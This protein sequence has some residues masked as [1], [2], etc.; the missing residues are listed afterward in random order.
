MALP[1]LPLD[2]LCGSQGPACSHRV[3]G[4]KKGVPWLRGGPGTACPPAPSPG[5]VP[6][7]KDPR[8]VTRN[9]SGHFP[10]VKIPPRSGSRVS[11]LLR[12][13][14]V[15]VRLVGA[16]GSDTVL[17]ALERAAGWTRASLCPPLCA[18]ASV[19]AALSSCDTPGP[20]AGSAITESNG[21]C[22]Q[23]R[24]SLSP[25]TRRPAL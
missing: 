24:S 8:S 9:V 22:E 13:D 23:M 16:H 20:V 1:G 11:L 17:L 6:E 4:V 18:P 15:F 5:G 3:R 25:G 12:T 7:Q 2:V 21:S 10:T 14:L 19:V